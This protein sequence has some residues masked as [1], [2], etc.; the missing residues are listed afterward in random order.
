MESIHL[1]EEKLNEL[2][3]K[4][5][6]RMINAS[7]L[8]ANAPVSGEV[9]KAFSSHNQINKFLIF[10]VFQVWDMQINKLKHP[11]FN[12]E[13]EDIQ[14]TLNTL[15]S[16]IS[17]HIEISPADFRPMLERAAY[18]NLKLIFNPKEAFGNFFFINQDSISL[19]LYKKYSQFFSDL[20]F[21]VNSIL[22]FYEKNELAEIDKEGFFEK[23]D[24]VLDIFNKKSEE[25]F[26]SYRANIFQKITGESID[27]VMEEI[28]KAKQ[29]EEEAKRAAEEEERRKAEAEARKKAEEEAR[30]KAEEEAKRKAEEEARK[31][32]E[33]EARKKAEAEEAR[34]K[35]EE[36]ARIKA[37]E[38]ARKKAE[39]AEARRKAEEEA[40]KKEVS[41]F[42][43]IESKS[44]NVFDLDFDDVLSSSEE[45]IIEKVE[46]VK[47]VVDK[48]RIPDPEPI[49]ESAA[50][51][52][53]KNLAEKPV[54]EF[55]EM[56]ENM[57]PPAAQAPV[58][59]P[60]PEP[61]AE[62]KKD[63]VSFLDRFLSKEKNNGAVEAPTPVAETVEKPTSVLDKLNEKAKTV[64][65]TVNQKEDSQK[66]VLD[67]LNGS[68]TIKLDEIPI[69]K[70]Y[71]YVQKVFEG[72]NVRFRIIVDKINNSKDKSE[73]EDILNKFVLSNNNLDHNDSAVGEFIT[74]LRNR[75]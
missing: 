58:V 48:S 13:N 67:N 63:T 38:E 12:L 30:I 34:R 37:E 54:D 24:K 56:A 11:Y 18:N 41:F 46:E 75:F 10:Q 22:R 70:Q 36:E 39:E 44:D 50:P 16:Q 14:A 35:A 32:A 43:E 26:A 52:E 55:L 29:E 4:A 65:E 21:V 9:L 49:E 69:H 60:A 7:D 62:T 47:E 66:Q 2:A 53:L 73:V 61:V 19:D 71:Q 45:S 8:D 31:K 68:K 1:P 72:N 40:K 57:E 17:Q 64:G 27:S 3:Q 25:S 23:M 15:K 51:V 28:N 6:E 74:L 42:D 20:D 5:S 59:D 33:E